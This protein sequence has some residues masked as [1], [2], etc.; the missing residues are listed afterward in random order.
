MKSK[1]AWSIART[2]VLIFLLILST[3]FITNPYPPSFHGFDA[4]PYGAGNA[5]DE[6]R[7]EILQQLREFQKGYTERDAKTVGAFARNLLSRDNTL[8]LGTMPKEIYIGHDDATTLIRDDWAFWGN[9]I[10]LVDQAHVS[11]HDNVAWIATV[12]YVEFDLSRFLVLPLRL[13]GVLVNEDGTWRFQLVQY[14]FDL[15]LIPNLLLVLFL[16]L[17]TGVSLLAIPIQVLLIRRQRFGASM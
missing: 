4:Q 9:C 17:L 10:F 16:G 13:S 1:I 14:Q 8:I 11:T 7:H 6:V 12:G 5:P 3:R 2:L 15:D